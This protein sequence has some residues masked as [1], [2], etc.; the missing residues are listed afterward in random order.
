MGIGLIHFYYFNFFLLP[1]ILK[2]KL[3]QLACFKL[4]D[5]FNHSKMILMKEYEREVFPM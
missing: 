4:C 3:G 2:I 5:Y 1:V